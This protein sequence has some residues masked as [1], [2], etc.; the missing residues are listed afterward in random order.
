MPQESFLEIAGA[1]FWVQRKGRGQPLL[2]LHGERGGAWTPALEAL[3]Q[4]FDVIAPELPGFGH[5][6]TPDWFD[7]IQDGAMFALELIEALALPRVHLAGTSIGAWTAL[8]AA[9]RSTERLARLA[10]VNPVGV[11][12]K[13]LAMPDP[14]MATPEEEIRNAFHDPR[15]A[16]AALATPVDDAEADRQ[17]K[18]RFAY[19]RLAWAP[20]LHDP[21]LAR[22]LHRIRRPTLVLCGA[23]EKVF[24]PAI[25]AAIAAAIPGARQAL[26]PNCGHVPELEQPA[27]LAEAIAGFI[28]ECAA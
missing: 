28:A 21:S 8:E 11:R 22:W 15:L 1:R 25:G 4:R 9:V 12:V 10:L 17:L 3:A 24:P 2:W 18:N 23:E 7:G 20:R 19:A 14:F 27:A 16:E 26:R 5:S 6:D 13:G